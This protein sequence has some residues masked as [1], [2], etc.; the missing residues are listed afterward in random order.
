MMQENGE[1]MKRVARMPRYLL[2]IIAISFVTRALAQTYIIQSSVTDGNGN[3]VAVA[4][5]QFTVPAPAASSTTANGGAAASTQ[6]SGGISTTATTLPTMSGQTY[7]S[8]RWLSTFI[9]DANGFIDLTPSIPA[10]AIRVSLPGMVGY[11]PGDSPDLTSAIAAANA[12]GSLCILFL[13]GNTYPL[14]MMDNNLDG[15]PGMVAHPWIITRTGPKGFDDHSLPRPIVCGGFGQAGSAVPNGH[16]WG[17][18]WS[19][20]IID[21]LDF[22]ADERD[23]ASPTY[24]KGT[25][26]QDWVF[27]GTSPANASSDHLLIADCR[28]RF[29]Q[30]GV[31]IGG[32]AGFPLNTVIFYRDVVAN[33]YGGA[34]QPG[35]FTSNVHDLL[36]YGGTYAGNGWNATA[37]PKNNGLGMQHDIYCSI[38]PAGTTADPQNRF[39]GLCVATAAAVGIEGNDGGLVD[40]C[41]FL[42]N[43]IGG[44]V[45]GGYSGGIQNFICDGGGGEFDA[46]AAGSA[47]NLVAPP[48]YAASRG[49]GV[50]LDCAPSG[51][52]QNGAIINKNDAADVQWNYGF[53]MGVHTTD[54]GKNG[55]GMPTAATVA[56][57]SDVAVSNWFE[58]SGGAASAPNGVNLSQ[59]GPPLATINFAG[60]DY[61]PGVT[62]VGNAASNTAG[63]TITGIANV[64]GAIPNYVDPARCASAYAKTLGI[65]GVSDGP[66]LLN[67][68]E[69][70]TDG[71]WN[72]ALDAGAA[73]DWIRA[74]FQAS[75][76][77][78]SR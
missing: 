37:Q 51:F 66:S 68:M 3:V 47:L 53:A 28:M 43:P 73:V 46:G 30:G 31:N 69:N 1:S 17:G 32:P 12:N 29:F 39:I 67:A 26:N 22:Y 77:S 61:L 55:E 75:A 6:P 72:P 64:I 7:E 38:N 63:A 8:D 44:Y 41:L 78:L 9:Y 35:V 2:A 4:T 54:S 62:G 24:V 42:A 65:A 71:N 40:H 27:T 70:L 33:C 11:Q 14:S 48:N 49:Y 34:T 15:A 56:T 18:P 52:I 16:N 25:Q 23:P 74:G 19:G 36:F 5:T 60:T 10:N 13:D 50:Y 58:W 20:L 21:G 45:G 57:I 76:P 59:A